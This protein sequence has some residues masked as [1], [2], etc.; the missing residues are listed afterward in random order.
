VIADVSLFNILLPVLIAVALASRGLRVDEDYMVSWANWFGLGLTQENRP[1]VRHYLQWS[2]RCRTVGGLA[3]F[4]APTI[5]FQV[6]TPGHQP[7]DVGGWAITTMLAGYLLG[8]L[9]AELVIDPPQRRSGNAVAVPVRLGGYLPTYVVVL[10]RGLAIAAVLLVGLYAL[11]E[12]GARFSGLPDLAQVAGLGVGAACMAAVV[13]AFQRRMVARPRLATSEAGV[14]ADH[15]MRASSLHVL[16]GG[17]IALLGMI[18]G[19][20]FLLPWRPSRRSPVLRGSPSWP[21]GS[22][23]FRR[24]IS[25]CTSASRGGFGVRRSER[26]RVT[27]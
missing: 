23:S 14:A 10:Q 20:M 3:G 4:L 12:P 6:V 26:H 17:G 1:A 8:A 24:C 19:P 18:A 21:W 22:R 13:E 25:G 5:Y 16:A 11:S 9:I 2:R 15:A 27:T 7:D